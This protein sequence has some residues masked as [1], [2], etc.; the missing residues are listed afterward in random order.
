MDGRSI[1]KQLVNMQQ[2]PGNGDEH[3]HEHEREREYE[4]G[5]TS[6]GSYVVRPPTVAY[7]EYH[8]LGPVGAPHR[9]LDSF[10]NTFRGIRVVGGFEQLRRI[11]QH[12]S[13]SNVDASL[14]LSG[15]LLYA[16]WGGDFEFRS[17]V[18]RELY[19]LDK[20]PWQMHNVHGQTSPA[21]EQA[22]ANLTR[23]LYRCQGA[24]CR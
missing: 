22:L 8:G 15:N 17:I 18:F 6:D 9:W 23:S 1:A 24:Q 4:R 10:N 5:S 12:F 7:I 21:V 3:E 2:E 11:Q 19:D 20:D 16:Q 13:G 14:R